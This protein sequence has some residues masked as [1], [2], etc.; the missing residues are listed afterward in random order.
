MCRHVYVYYVSGCTTS[1]INVVDDLAAVLL[2]REGKGGEEWEGREEGREGRR[3]GL[4]QQKKISG[5]ATANNRE[6]CHF[7]S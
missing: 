1:V 4:S 2:L 5:A 6:N 7:V 3:K